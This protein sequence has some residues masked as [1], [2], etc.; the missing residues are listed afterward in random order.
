[1]MNLLLN[2]LHGFYMAAAALGIWLG[3]VLVTREIW[4]WYFKLNQMRDL[5]SNIHDELRT[6][7]AKSLSGSASPS[8]PAA[9]PSKNWVEGPR[10]TTKKVTPS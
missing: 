5:L 8:T 9:S 1:M 6:L 4:C 3:I 7:N 10:E 2:P